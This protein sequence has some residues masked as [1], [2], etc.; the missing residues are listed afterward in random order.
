M[1]KALLIVII[2]LIF[3]L[4]GCYKNTN[5][6]Q[7]AL[8]QQIKQNNTSNKEKETILF[9]SNI[10]PHCKKVESFIKNN[11][12]GKKIKFQQKEINSNQENRNEL[13]EKA[14]QCDIPLNKIGVPFLWNNGK[15]LMGDKDIINFFEEKING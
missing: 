5:N 14:K 6:P 7:G 13:V 15:C 12:I 11:D 8:S 10:C 1:K 9:Y 3:F 2:I 4:G